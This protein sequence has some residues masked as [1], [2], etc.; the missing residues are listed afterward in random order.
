MEVP[1]LIEDKQAFIEETKSKSN[2]I[3]EAIK[4]DEH[5]SEIMS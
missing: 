4:D 1:K 3:K 5:L 2:A